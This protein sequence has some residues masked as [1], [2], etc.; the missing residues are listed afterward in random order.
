MTTDLPRIS[1]PSTEVAA[2]W[3]PVW[4]ATSDDA[5]RP[6]LHRTICIEWFDGRGLRLIATDSYVLLTSWLGV[7]EHTPEPS[8]DERPLHTTIASDPDRRGH[9]LIRYAAACAAKD[10]DTDGTYHRT[11]LTVGPPA[12]SRKTPALAEALEQQVLTIGYEGETV[13]LLIVEA[14][15][16]SW[17][18]LVSTR[19]TEATEQ[20]ALSPHVLGILAKTGREY[21]WTFSGEL[22]GIHIRSLAGLPVSGVAM[23]IRVSHLEDEEAA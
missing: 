10:K 16:P 20:I 18:N 23:P 12:A 2:A 14:E 8:L 19:Q 7:T 11:T 1:L 9:G 3:L 15:Y 21:A 6:I 5:D 17:R 22:G 13:E 4:C